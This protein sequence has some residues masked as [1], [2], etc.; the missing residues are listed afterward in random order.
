M[1]ARCM[2][3]CDQKIFLTHTTSDYVHL[4]TV[5]VIQSFENATKAVCR[6]FKDELAEHIFE[7]FET[8]VSA[9]ARDSVET[10]SKVRNPMPA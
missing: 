10:A 6:E 3:T 4:L 2:D 7:K 9:A 5:G 8:A 1:S